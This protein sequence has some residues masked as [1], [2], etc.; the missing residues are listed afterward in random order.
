MTHS[1][2]ADSSFVR[3]AN[4][5]LVRDLLRDVGLLARAEIA[6][7]TNLSRSTVSSIV[8]ELIDS[9]FVREV[10]I[11]QS[12][13]GRRPVLLE[14][15]YNAR[16]IVG[17]DIGNN[18][19]LGVLANLE[20]RVLR[21]EEQ[22]IPL[23]LS[24]QQTVEKLGGL[25]EG[26]SRQSNVAV[27]QVLGIGV[28]IPAPL[29]YHDGRIANQAILA[30]WQGVR[31]GEELSKRLG[32][33]CLIDNDANLGALGEHAWGAGRGCA[34]MAYIKL[35]TGVGG[36]LILNGALYRGHFGSAGEIGHITIDA[37]GP[38]CRCGNRGCLEAMV[39][40]QV[41]L[42]EAADALRAGRHSLLQ[43]DK[44]SVE[45][46]VDAARAG[47][48]LA[49][50]VLDRAGTAIGVAVAGL[51]NMLNLPLVV[52]SGGLASAGELLLGPIRVAVRQRCLPMLAAGLSIVGAQLVQ[53]A[54][55]LGA[56]RLVLQEVFSKPELFPARERTLIT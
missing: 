9:G 47:D 7:R 38:Y 54:V 10:G 35:G 42:A 46:L 14:F 4:K 5:A 11:G 19:L 17:C 55:G 56:V 44:L 20:G 15:N 25:I 26:L 30:R 53:D 8:S 34:N 43:P 39:S 36:G 33:P 41:L 16:Y 24:W 27:E 28:G 21:R 40:V 22:A 29:A 48:A 18:H 13:G 37:D 6:R 1:A 2:I 12:S 52:I 45:A 50:E 3:E 51:V 49:V 23:G 32:L 31:I